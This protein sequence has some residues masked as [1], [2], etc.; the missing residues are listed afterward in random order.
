LEKKIVIEPPMPRSKWQRMAL[1]ENF[2]KNWEEHFSNSKDNP[3]RICLEKLKETRT[4]R[5]KGKNV[6]EIDLQKISK[7]IQQAREQP[8][9]LPERH[10][11]RLEEGAP[12]HFKQ[13]RKI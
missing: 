13:Q 8:Y 4:Q 12:N 10:I 2:A 1:L 3:Y 11:Q 6:D 7:L 5:I 9:S